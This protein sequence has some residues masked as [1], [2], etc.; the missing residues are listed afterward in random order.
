[1]A[2][3]VPTSGIGIEPISAGISAATQIVSTIAGISDMNKRRD[4]EQ[5]LGRLSLAEQNAIAREL[6]RA[7]T[8]SERLAILTNAVASIRSAET[9]QKLKNLGMEEADRRKKEMTMIYLIV[10]LGIAAVLTVVL[11]KKV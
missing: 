7:K 4:V 5:A 8:Q 10:G 1:M 9:T 2:A 11:I 3:Q 6:N